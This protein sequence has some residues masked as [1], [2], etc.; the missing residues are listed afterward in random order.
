MLGLVLGLVIG[1]QSGQV[2]ALDMTLHGGVGVDGPGPGPRVCP[3]ADRCLPPPWTGGPLTEDHRRTVTGV[4]VTAWIDHSPGDSVIQRMSATVPQRVRGIL[5]ALPFPA[6]G[7][8][9]PPERWGLFQGR[10]LFE[11]RALFEVRA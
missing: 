5:G 9:Q 1:G 8:S 3:C 10:A 7:L 11:L 4:S 2:V 6:S